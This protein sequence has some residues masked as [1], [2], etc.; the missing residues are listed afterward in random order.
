MLYVVTEINTDV[1]RNC[2]PVHFAIPRLRSNKIINL[3]L[4]EKNFIFAMCKLNFKKLI[5]I[6]K[7]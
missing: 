4:R 7:S 5:N 2:D 6:L 1:K 3:T